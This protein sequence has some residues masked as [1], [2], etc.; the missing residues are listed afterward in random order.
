MDAPLY[1]PMIY[2]LDTETT[3]V[4][5]HHGARPY[6]V[7]VCD[8]EGLNTWWEW[9]VDPLT[10]QPQFVQPDIDEI[11]SLI[12]EADALVLQNAKFDFKALSKLP[13]LEEYEWP[14]HKVHDTLISGHLLA[15]NHAHDLT[16]M[17]LEYLGV[18]LQP[19]EDAMEKVVTN[20][21]NMIRRK[22]SPVSNWAKAEAGRPDMPSAKEKTWKFDSWMPR[23]AAKRK[24]PGWDPSW[25]TV[26]SDYANSDSCATIELF[27]AHKEHLEQRKLDK[28]YEMRRELIPVVYATENGGVTVSEERLDNLYK[29]YEEE[30]NKARSICQNIARGYD[31]FELTLP[32][33]GNNK[34]L[35]TFVFDVMKLQPIVWSKKTGAPSLG[36]ET[37]EHFEATL[38]ERTKPHMFVSQLRGIRARGTALTYLEAY[39]RFAVPLEQPGFFRL[40][41]SLNITGTDTLRFS[42]SNPNEQNISK[43]EGFNLR[44]CFGPG[45][46]REWWSLD[47]KNIELRLPAYESEEQELIDLFERPD[48]PPYYGS[49]HLLNFHTV[50]PD[51]WEKEEQ[52]VGFEKVGPHCKKKFAA[53]WYQWCKNGGFAVQYGAVERTDKIGTADRAFHREGS[54][55]KLKARFNKLEKLNQRCIQHAN[56]FGYVETIPDKSVDPTKGYPL[57]CTRSE[58][59]EIL[60]TVPLNYHIQGSAMWWMCK[61][62]IRCQKQLNEWKETEGFQANIVMQVHDELVFEMPYGPE[63][64][65]LPKAQALASIMALGG[66]D[67]GI[68]TPVGIE[69]N[70]ET[71][72]EGKTL[73]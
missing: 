22:G 57:L 65:N 67:F 56:K 61:A 68:P 40:H 46:G 14:W 32:K 34:S 44:Y 51:L 6:L 55:S 28:I 54:H 27:K 41:P 64:S 38:K 62:M 73:A 70:P 12:E 10:R 2:S 19:Y 9:E 66:E 48:E 23:V 42:S 1:L 58:Y 36:K 72:S 45:P 60:P 11:L 26:T 21:R 29:Q 5:F 7:T 52:L 33:S 53:T 4:D 63:M 69:Y 15:S 30:G 18:D 59:G 35:T 8:E 25:L 16:S 50:Y 17:A 13:G 24:V 31:D 37:I 47:A 20:I 43:R 39:R 71:W 3:G 49:T